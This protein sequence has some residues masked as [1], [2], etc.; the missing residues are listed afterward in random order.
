VLCQLRSKPADQ[1]HVNGDPE[2]ANHSL[3]HIGIISPVLQKLVSKSQAL[4]GEKIS[5]NKSMKK[6]NKLGMMALCI[7]I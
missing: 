3:T 5:N 4:K 2:I 7:C 1:K 6:C